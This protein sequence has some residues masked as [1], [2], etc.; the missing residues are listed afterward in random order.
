[1]TPATYPAQSL[2]P[3]SPV[4]KYAPRFA[5][6]QLALNSLQTNNAILIKKTERQETEIKLMKNQIREMKGK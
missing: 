6:I 2:T 3:L 5:L 1:M 4:D